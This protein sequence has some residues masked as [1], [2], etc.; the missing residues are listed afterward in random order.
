MYKLEHNKFPKLFNNNFVKI[1]NH[2]KYGT[3][4]ATSSNYFLP[5]VGKKLAQNQLSFKGSKLGRTINLQI[6]NKNGI[7]LRSNI[8]RP[9]LTLT[10]KFSSKLQFLWF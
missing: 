3:R 10:E 2:H 9:Y 6:K 5:R 8:F 4:Q 1:T 7:H